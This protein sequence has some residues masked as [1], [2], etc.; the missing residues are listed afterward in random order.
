MHLVSLSETIA[1]FVLKSGMKYC[2]HTHTDAV[3]VDGSI[4][5]WN[6]NIWLLRINNWVTISLPVVL[7]LDTHCFIAVFTVVIRAASN[8][9]F[10]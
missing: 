8:N 4:Q 9:Y 6:M 2:K 3:C 5:N 10:K 7:V 1:G